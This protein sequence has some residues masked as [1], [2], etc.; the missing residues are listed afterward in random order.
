MS[1][2]HDARVIPLRP[3]PNV[4]GR[5]PPHN[6]DAEAAVLSA[7]MLA[8]GALDR[9][10]ALL[11]PEH[12]YSDSNGQI[13]EAA[14]ALQ[15]ANRP[16]DNVTVADWLRTRQ[17][18]HS[19][20]GA[21]Y[22]AQITDATPSVVNLEHHARIVFDA[23]RLRQLI[24]TCQ[25]IAAEGYGDVGDPGEFLSAAAVAVDAVT[26]ADERDAAKPIGDVAKAVF[27]R[28]H[29]AVARKGLTGRSTGLIALD[30]RLGGLTDGKTTVIGARAS[31]GKTALAR[32]IADAVAGQGAA[33]AMFSM[34]TPREEL[35]DLWAFSRARVNKDRLKERGQLSPNEWAAV[36]QA[37][38][39][40]EHSPIW[41]D[42]T[43]GLTLSQLRAKARQVRAAAA[44]RNVKLGLLVVDYL[45]LMTPEGMTRGASREQ[46]VSKLSRGIKIL[47]GE[48]GVHV[49]LLSQINRAL[50]NRGVRDKRPTMAELRESGAIEADADNIILIYR[51]EYYNENTQAKGIAELILAKQRGGRRGVTVPVAFHDWCTRFEDLRD[52]PD[53][54][55]VD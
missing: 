2:D 37:L 36:T 40:L 17:R 13:F 16:T 22:L 29:E 48:L 20:G 9:A 24:A 50:E 15:R 28:L 31:M 51:D 10:A 8:P 11:K 41:I 7:V 32:G 54:R 34:E 47:A 26:H 30:R 46:E 18:L 33:V 52:E 53:R 35:L 49:L 39:E 19:V 6:L 14:R 12:F 38:T 55:M 3:L 45:Q 27:Q 42:D 44:R 5:V 4:A 23:W 25:K 1:R 21:S 43:P